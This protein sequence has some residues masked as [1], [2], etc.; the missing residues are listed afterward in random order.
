VLS[1]KKHR[2]NFTF[3]LP[4]HDGVLGDWMYNSIHYLTSALGGSEWL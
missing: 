4:G 3:T 1:S 2:D